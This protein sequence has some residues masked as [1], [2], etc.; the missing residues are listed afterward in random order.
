MHRGAH[1]LERDPHALEFGQRSSH[2]CN[3]F[4][5]A[6]RRALVGIHPCVRGGLFRSRE[7]RPARARPLIWVQRTARLRCGNSRCCAGFRMPVGH[8][9][10][11]CESSGPASGSRQRTNP[12]FVLRGA[13]L[14]YGDLSNAD[15]LLGHAQ[16]ALI[17]SITFIII[18]CSWVRSSR[19]RVNPSIGNRVWRRNAANC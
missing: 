2:W 13:P 9:R 7:Y 18:I 4:V 5:H 16:R 19:E 11:S 12:R 17:G 14:D 3:N 15:C 6:G 1:G 10:G 8:A